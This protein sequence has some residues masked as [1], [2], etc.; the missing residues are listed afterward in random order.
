[1]A[2]PDVPRDRRRHDADRPGSGDEDVLADQVEREGGV[3]GVA[4]RVEEGGDVV[5][6]L[7]GNPEDVHRRDR[8]EFGEAAGALHAQADRVA[9]QVALP[10]AAVAAMAAGDVPFGADPFTPGEAG[11][12]ASDGRD[13]AGELVADDHRHRDGFLRPRVPVEDV[14]VGAADRRLPDPDEQV[15]GPELGDGDFREPQ[16]RLA[17]RLDQRLH[18]ITPSWRPTLPKAARARSRCSRS[19]AAE[20]CVRMRAWPRGTTGN[21]KPIT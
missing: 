20:I 14:D 15:V 8:D 3:H 10:G 16:T 2:R 9:A 1:M 18:W 21:E 5:G 6:D 17:L 19:W 4:E 11:H 13:L 7:L 12:R